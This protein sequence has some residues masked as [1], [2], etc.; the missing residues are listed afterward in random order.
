M[1]L[2]SHSAALEICR[3][4]VWVIIAAWMLSLFPVWRFTGTA[5]WPE[6][7]TRLQVSPSC[8]LHLAALQLVLSLRSEAMLRGDV[9]DYIIIL[10]IHSLHRLG[11]GG[12]FHQSRWLISCEMKILSCD[13]MKR[14]EFIISMLTDQ[15]I[16][17]LPLCRYKDT[18]RRVAM[19]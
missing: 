5:P 6:C 12:L 11:G 13:H 3:C 16:I 17:L 2:F 1:T 8:W 14:P 15:W 9:R 4:F 18:M 10:V 7:S 19:K